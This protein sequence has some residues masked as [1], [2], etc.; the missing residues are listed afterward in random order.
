MKWQ[1]TKENLRIHATSYL[2]MVVAG[3][4]LIVAI[5]I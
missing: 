2:G 3:L 4:T 5:V 1:E